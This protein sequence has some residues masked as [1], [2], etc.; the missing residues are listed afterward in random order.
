[1]DPTT[2]S[3]MPRFRDAILRA[4][5][6]PVISLAVAAALATSVAILLVYATLR[7]TPR[8]PLDELRFAE[9]Q[10]V[11][12]L[13]H[14]EQWPQ[15]ARWLVEYGLEQELDGPDQI[16]LF[17]G[18]RVPVHRM[19]QLLQGGLRV[20]PMNQRSL[21][22][23]PAT[24][25]Q[26]VD[27]VAPLSVAAEPSGARGHWRAVVIM[28]SEDR[29]LF[30][31]APD[32]EMSFAAL[33]KLVASVFAATLLC[34]G[35]FVAL[36]LWAFRRWFA[37]GSAEALAL[38]VERLADAMTRFMKDQRYPIEVAV[39]PPLELAELIQI[40]NSLQH[41]VSDSLRQSAKAREDQSNFVAEISHE[42]RTPLT[43]IRGHAE[44]LAREPAS[45][46][47]AEIIVRQVDDLHILLSDL[48]DLGRM[49]SINANMQ[50]EP[51]GLATVLEEMHARFQAP[52]WKHGVLLRCEGPSCDACV[53]A[54][55][56]WLRQVIA[57]L[58]ANAIRHT[59]NG[60]CVS[61]SAGKNSGQAF[62]RIDDTGPGIGHDQPTV[63]YI[64]RNAGIGLRVVRSLLAS[65]GGAINT[66]PNED[67][68][69]ATILLLRLQNS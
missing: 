26:P 11:L 65:M 64:G 45:V 2:S 56:R 7:W 41:H 22:Q 53:V 20:D 21:G 36:F 3:G 27:R 10:S 40:N 57:N 6:R 52:A 15:L 51:V 28:L 9:L 13:A 54:D 66:E 8:N 23:I 60:G 17:D 38:P 50:Q 44:R 16:R 55:S 37:A 30:V 29:R 5:L 32:L 31:Q 67:G 1:M 46:G 59:P 14:E 34:V 33:A 12:G 42:L 61:V 19:V 18:E 58:L 69:T 47:S 35:C 63:D 48:I 49:H 68:G 39:T 43:V 25:M 24:W 62:I 4:Q